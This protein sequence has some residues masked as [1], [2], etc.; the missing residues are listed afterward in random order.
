M[1]SSHLER[2][3]MYLKAWWRQVSACSCSGSVCP[4]ETI[5]PVRGDAVHGRA[6]HMHMRRQAQAEPA[7][8]A[9][10][11]IFLQGRRGWYSV[12]AAEEVR[13]DLPS[14]EDTQLDGCA[15]E[16]SVHTRENIRLGVDSS[17]LVTV[18]EG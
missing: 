15:R 4:H 2:N 1:L 9:L 18:A 7:E 5:F 8:A 17:L 11:L 3:T 12:T 6:L 14:A 10:W 16:A 13:R